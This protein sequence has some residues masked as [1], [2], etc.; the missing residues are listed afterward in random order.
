MAIEEEGGY[1][2]EVLEVKPNFQNQ[3]EN[4]SKDHAQFRERIRDILPELNA[5]NDWNEAQFQEVCEDLNTLLNDIDRHDA[6]EIDVLEESL[7][8]DEGGEG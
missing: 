2:S 6:A 1:M 3:I 5:L 8:I 4:L 7:W